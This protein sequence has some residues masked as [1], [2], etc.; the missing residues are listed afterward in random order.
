MIASI[1]T[2][3]F[4]GHA[5]E[6]ENTAAS[7]NIKDLPP[8]KAKTRYSALTHWSGILKLRRHKE[9]SGNGAPPAEGPPCIGAPIGK[10]RTCS[11]GKPDEARGDLTRE[12]RKAG[13]LALGLI[14]NIA[15]IIPFSAGHSL[16]SQ[17]YTIGRL[18]LFIALGLWIFL[19][20][21]LGQIYFFWIAVRNLK[22]LNLGGR[23]T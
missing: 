16:H 10:W 18:L 14:T 15:A 20:I 23:D 7:K 8:E 9:N 5:G 3:E 13:F 17:A 19:M 6:A 22:R 2:N 4:V 21:S 12:I 11:M 1:G